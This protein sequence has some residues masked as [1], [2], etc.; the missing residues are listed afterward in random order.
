MRTYNTPTFVH[1]CQRMYTAGVLVHK[2]E[3]GN[4]RPEWEGCDDYVNVNIIRWIKFITFDGKEMVSLSVEGNDHTCFMSDAVKYFRN[5][6]ESELK[7]E[8]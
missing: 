2:D 8:E 5:L 1:I 6:V 7:E 4:S 3:Y